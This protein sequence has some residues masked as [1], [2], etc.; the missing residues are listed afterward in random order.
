MSTLDT[1]VDLADNRNRNMPTVKSLPQGKLR[2]AAVF[3]EERRDTFQSLVQRVYGVERRLSDLEIPHDYD[4]RQ[5]LIDAV[6][7]LEGIRDDIQTLAA[8]VGTEPV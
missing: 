3:A 1:V 2:R 4:T 8:Q 6:L 7:M 5:A